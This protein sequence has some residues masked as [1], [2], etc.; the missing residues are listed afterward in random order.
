MTTQA[1]TK[2]QKIFIG[3]LGGITPIF[4][5]LLVIDI[6]IILFN[7]NMITMLGFMTRVIILFYVGGMLAYLN[8]EDDPVK[9]FQLGIVAPAMITAIINGNNVASG[10]NTSENLVKAERSYSLHIPLISVAHA[11][12]AVEVRTIS[13][14]EENKGKDFW[15]VIVGSFLVKEDA[16]KWAEKVQSKG[17]IA[18]VYYP[19]TDRNYYPVVIGVLSSYQE[20]EKLR[21]K[22][23]DAGFSKDTYLWTSPRDFSEEESPTQKFLRGFL[24][25]QSKNVW[26]V[27]AGSHLRE[28]DAQVQAKEIRSIGFEA[29]V[30]EPSEGKKYYSVVIGSFLEYS[31][32]KQLRQKAIEAGL[33]KSTYL[34][35]FR[36][37]IREEPEQTF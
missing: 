29:N 11:N 8:K 21:Q 25:L 4:V 13:I 18:T 26:F 30:Y 10:I 14:T 33:P 19:H 9:V 1:L 31:D 7:L 23:I 3:G 17:F 2:K 22:A 6:H 34:W 15:Y 20:A 24:G 27:I 16:I 36:D 5:N 37:E 28:D 32:A 35:T 12:T